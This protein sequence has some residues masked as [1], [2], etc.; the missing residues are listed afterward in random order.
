MT[1]KHLSD[2][3]LMMTYREG[4]SEAFHELYRRYSGKI[5][6]YLRKK[7]KDEAIASDIFQE[8]FMKLHR[9][10]HLYK[11]SLPFK[12]WLFTVAQSTLIDHLRKNKKQMNHSNIDAEE[13]ADTNLRA[14]IINEDLAILEKLPAN[15]RTVLQMRYLDE[16]TFQEIAE[17]LK[18]SETNA[19]QIVSRTIRNLKLLIKGKKA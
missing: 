18:T 8:V 17:V 6:G 4:T 12:P 13:I 19:R 14:D 11:E 10:K 7:V 2:E 3:E 16:K 15:Q 5:F 9:S 1:F